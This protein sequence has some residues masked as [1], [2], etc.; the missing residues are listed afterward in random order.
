MFSDWKGSVSSAMKHPGAMPRVQGD[1]LIRQALGHEFNILHMQQDKTG[2][3]IN[4]GQ[5]QFPGAGNQQYRFPGMPNQ[6]SR[7]GSVP[8]GNMDPRFT[9]TSCRMPN[10]VP[11]NVPAPVRQPTQNFAPNFNNYAQMQMPQNY[12]S[13]ASQFTMNQSLPVP[14]PAH[15][16][17]QKM[18]PPRYQPQPATM[19]THSHGYNSNIPR[20][21]QVN[22]TY[23]SLPQSQGQFGMGSLQ[24]HMTQGHSAVASGH[25]QGYVPQCQNAYHGQQQPRS[26][27]QYA[28]RQNLFQNQTQQQPNRTVSSVQNLGFP[29]SWE[30]EKLAGIVE[31]ISNL[32][33]LT[34]NNDS[35]SKRKLM[36][37]KEK[38]IRSGLLG[39][40]ESFSAFLAK[41]AIRERNKILGQP[42]SQPSV[43]NPSVSVQTTA[44][45]TASF[46]KEPVKGLDNASAIQSAFAI[47]QSHDLHDKVAL[48][49]WYAEPSAK[50]GTSAHLSTP[51]GSG[52]TNI[53]MGKP[54][55]MAT[56]TTPTDTPSQSSATISQVAEPF[57]LRPTVCNEDVIEYKVA[58]LL[59]CLPKSVRAQIAK[60]LE[61]ENS[62]E[63]SK[64][65][66][67]KDLNQE[68]A[69]SSNKSTES[70]IPMLPDGA[71]EKPVTE[72]QKERERSTSDSREGTPGSDDQ[73][74]KT[75]SFLDINK[76]ISD[77]L[78]LDFQFGTQDMDPDIDFRNYLPQLHLPT[79][80]P[81]T[82]SPVS[83]VIPEL[84][85]SSLNVNSH[86][87]NELNVAS[88]ENI[89]DLPVHHQSVTD[90]N[91]YH[92]RGENESGIAP[93]HLLEPTVEID[94]DEE[95]I[96]IVKK[97]KH[98]SVSETNLGK[99]PVK[100]ARGRGR[101]GATRG[102]G[103]LL[104]FV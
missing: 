78:V 38:C 98:S 40:N 39:P 81:A 47:P 45:T 3:Y 8:G 36:Q 34:E 72:S 59:R 63:Q 35:A 79:N 50:M 46:S 74:G 28:Q 101:G 44:T 64:V 20:Q 84:E 80:L 23:G 100:R 86:T 1:P 7:P 32:A 68:T 29:A 85:K 65:E 55:S 62:C 60:N 33:S 93:D 14:P 24:G 22:T 61:S 10:N 58:D 97:R 104:F 13:T 82:P 92:A 19:P 9:N 52:T 57:V 66:S 43:Y 5:G 37:I 96:P 49:R 11:Q 102:R 103:M 54:V 94:R 87:D 83:P 95:P 41:Y 75:D 21:P 25:V 2:N 42:T 88:N 15:Q 12:I 67:N 17:V 76:R 91:H 30:H 69:H 27:N 56:V 53:N 71:I 70:D 16:N 26:Q 6:M 18:P 4:Q 31:T 73:F 99:P 77:E 51:E 90:D 89:N 48:G